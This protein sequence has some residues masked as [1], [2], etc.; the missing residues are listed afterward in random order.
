[1][2]KA[3]EDAE[4]CIS[5]RP[6]WEKGYFRKGSVLEGLNRLEEA[7]GAYREAAEY[8]PKNP[9]VAN[10]IKSLSKMLR[11]S[12][13]AQGRKASEEA[14]AGGGGQGQRRRRR[15]HRRGR[16]REERRGVRQ[17]EGQRREFPARN[18]SPKPAAH[19]ARSL[20]LILCPHALPQGALAPAPPSLPRPRLLHPRRDLSRSIRLK[21]CAQQVRAEAH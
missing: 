4:R 15:R 13:N 2:Q 5:L 1:M 8:N 3:L 11:N 12:R 20:A 19:S 6:T 16:F 9:E 17:G 18:R 7:L 10:K 14:K 21:A